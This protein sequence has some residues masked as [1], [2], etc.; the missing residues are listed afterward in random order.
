MFSH[1]K[2]LSCLVLCLALLGTCI[3]SGC[4]PAPSEG[5]PPQPAPSSQPAAAP[6]TAAKDV[7]VNYVDTIPWDATYDV[8]VVGF[9]GAGAVT[10]ITAADE[11][12]KVL[13]VDKAPEGEEGGNTRVCGQHV[14]DFTNV[15]DGVKYLKEVRGLFTNWPDEF[16]ETFVQRLA[17]FEDW[18]NAF[19]YTEYETRTRADYELPY[20]ESVIMYYTELP[21][22]PRF[23]EGLREQ[24]MKRPDNIEVWFKSPG[25]ELIQ[26][27]FTKTIL[28]VKIEVDGKMVNVRALNGVVL[29]TGGFENNPQMVQDYLQRPYAGLLGGVYNTGDGILMAQAVGADLWHMNAT[30]GPYP[31]FKEPGSERSRAMMTFAGT[32]GVIYVG[33]DGTRFFDESF[34]PQHGYKMFH[35]QYMTIPFPLPAYMIMDSV[36]IKDKIIAQW[37]EGNAEEIAK[38]WIK[39]ADTLE[40]LAEMIGIP[41]ESLV[42][43]V[44]QYNGFVAAGN[45]PLQ[46]RPA[47]KLVKIGEG[48]YYAL[49]IT[50]ANLNTQGGPRRNVDCEI[51]DTAGNVIPNLYGVGELGSMHPGLYQGGS[52]LAECFTSG[53]IAGENAAKVKTPPAATTLTIAT[54]P[55]PFVYQKEEI[56]IKLG[57][58]EYLG[59][60]TGMGGEIIVKVTMDGDKIAAVEVVK[61]TETVG[62]ADKALSAIPQAIVAANSPDV[63]AVSGA[64][65]TSNG[66]I[67]GV[68]DALSQK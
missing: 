40:A 29:A 68:K 58:N 45:D 42:S 49:E 31:A 21:G 51:L 62:I 52:N 56:D 18:W 46:G 61:Q 53:Q 1:Y 14:V 25:K 19:G 48:P 28:G 44:E 17:T 23:W 66:I 41:A 43:T 9:G 57:A 5:P 26:D 63:D 12:A 15:G 32:R 36:A 54:Q 67:N 35:G 37:S 64:T 2:R 34:V 59:K 30:S 47:D 55:A 50:P 38:G 4:A 11:G 24:V 33:P 65:M 39:K 8:V 22:K 6:D 20:A 27:P 7:T 10:A 16:I 13:L 3:L 60:G